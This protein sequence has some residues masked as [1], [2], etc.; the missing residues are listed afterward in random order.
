[1]QLVMKIGHISITMRVG[2][3]EKTPTYFSVKLDK[4]ICLRVILSLIT[5]INT[6]G[7]D[8]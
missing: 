2:E 7:M 4:N 5:K 1:M 8:R 6:L 3:T